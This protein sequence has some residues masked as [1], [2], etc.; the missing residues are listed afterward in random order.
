MRRIWKRLAIAALVLIVS[1]LLFTTTASFQQWLLRR[2]ENYAKQA[3][4]PFTA[5]RL[6]VVWSEL[7]LSLDGLT[8]DQDGQRLRVEH[9]N[10]DLPWRPYRSGDLRIT[11]FEADGVVID[12]RS[13]GSTT[14][15]TA[16]TASQPPH[17]RIDHLAI[18]NAALSFSSPGT[19][20]SAPAVSLEAT[21]GR[22]SILLSSPVSIS[23]DIQFEV[24]RIPFVLLDDSLQFGSMDW[25]IRYADY[26]GAG[27]ADGLVRWAPA[28]ALNA[29]IATEA[30]TIQKWKDI[31]AIAK[32]SYAEGVLDV[33]EFRATQAGGEITGSAK[34]SDVA[35]SS[36]ISWKDLRLDPIG[37]IARTDGT[38]ELGW[39]A[40]DFSDALGEGHA[41]VRSPQYGTADTNIT[42]SNAKATVDARASVMDAAVRAKIT[43][44]LDQ[45]LRGT[46]QVVYRKYGLVELGGTVAGTFQNPTANGQLRVTGA[47]YEEFGPLNASATTTFR[48]NIVTLEEIQAESKRS[49]LSGGTV[50][51]NVTNRRIHGDVPQIQANLNDFAPQV[52]GVVDLTANID[53]SLEQPAASFRG[54]SAGIDVGGTHID[55]VS[56]DGNFANNSLRVNRLEAHQADGTLV[57]SGSLNIAT[58]QVDAELEAS[59]IDIVQVADLSTTVFM[60]AKVH[61]AYR[62]P[63]TDFAGELRDVVYQKQEHGTV[64]LEGTT[65]GKVATVQVSAD[66]YAATATGDITVEEPYPFTM[67]LKA[68]HTPIQYEQY[69]FIAE[70]RIEAAGQ[71]QPLKATHLRFDKFTLAAE[72]VDLSADGLLDTGIRLNVTADLPKLP[73]KDM[74]LGGTAEVMATVRGTINNPSI[75]GAL[76][77]RNATVRT[78]EMTDAATVSADVDFTGAEFSIRDLRASFEEATA[79]VTGRGSWQGTGQF[80]FRVENLKPERFIKDRPIKG[81]ASVEGEVN[82]A[83]PTLD[84]VSGRARVTQLELTVR[85]VAIHQTQPIEAEIDHHVLTVRQLELEGLD[86]HARVTGNANLMDRTLN[87]EAEADTD[88]AVLQPF[89]PNASPGGRLKTHIALNGTPENPNLDGFVNVSGGELTLEQ[90][91]IFLTAVEVAAEL[92][93]DHVQIT[94]ATGLVNGGPFEASGEATISAN[95][96][97]DAR[98][99]LKL[100]HAQMDYPPGLNSEVSAELG[101]NGSMPALTLTGDVNVLNAL[102]EERINLTQEVFSRITSRPVASGITPQSSIGDQI[103]MEVNVQT[104]GPV[105]IKNNL[106]DLEITG[107]FRVRG[108]ASN[109]IILGRAIVQDGGELYFGPSSGSTTNQEAALGQRGDRYTIERGAIDFNNPLR[110]EPTF[111]FEA[112][113]ELKF[114]KDEDYLITLTVTGT[115][116]TLKTELTSSDPTQTKTDIIFMLVTGRSPKDVE[117][118]YVSIA[119]EQ[120][121]NYLSGQLTERVL[122]QAGSVLG[123][124]TVRIDPVTVANQTDVTARLTIGKDI[125]KDFS[126]AYSQ[127][128]NDSNA[129]TWIASYAAF[130]NFVVRGVNDTEQN[131]LQFDLNHEIRI[132]GGPELPKR[133]TLKNEAVL[134]NITFTGTQL[135]MKDLLKQVTKPGKPFNVFRMNGDVR[136]L[137]RYYASN[138]FPLVRIQAQQTPDNGK[139]DVHFKIMDGPRV[140]LEYEGAKVPD[141][142]KAEINQMWTTRPAEGPLLRDTT[143]RLLRHFRSEGY[144]QA[145]VSDKDMSTGP[146]YRHHVFIIDPGKEFGAPTWIFKGVDP[147]AI[148]E[149]AGVVMEHPEAV[150]ERIEASFRPNGYLDAT[151]TIPMLEIEENRAHFV[152]TVNRGNQ[153]I[154]DKVEF[155]GNV[156]LEASRL[157]DAIKRDAIKKEADKTGES[158]VP[159]TSA[160]LETAR[161]RVTSE[162][163]E[164]GF[165]DVQIVPSTTSDPDHSRVGVRF[166]ISEGE[167]QVIKSVEVEGATVTDM[168]YIQRHLQFKTGDPVDYSKFNLTRKKLYDT[169]L[170]RRVDIEAVP[171]GEGYVARVRLNE[172]PP[173]RLRYGFVVTDHL[174][175][176]E[177]DLGVTSDISYNNLFGR[178][179]TTGGRIKVDADERDGRV[180]GSVPEFYGRN[181]TTTVTL[182]RTRELTDPDLISDF[183]GVTAQQQWRFQKYYVLS[184]DYSF[185]KERNYPRD[186]TDSSQGNPRIPIARFNGTVSR[187]TRDDILNAARGTFLSNSFEIAPPGIGSS[188]LFFRNYS[189]YLHFKPVKKSLVWASGFRIGLGAGF[190]GQDLSINDKF[191]AGGGSSV[192]GFKQDQLTPE[193]G[194][195]VL[196]F[197]Q[198]LRFPVLWKFSGV[199]FVDAGLVGE[200]LE[201]VVDLSQL[202]YGT[203]FGLRIHTPFVLLRTDLGW[204]IRPRPGES[205]ARFSFGIGQAF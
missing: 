192:R 182:F 31:R 20:I 35:N 67:E 62:L 105:A 109:P 205:T 157:R 104:A 126:L 43:T 134:R 151:S 125:T 200:K 140:V 198:E 174:Q 86:T 180:F 40:P 103:R 127:I 202:R 123:L 124:N 66:K 4:F 58:E 175:T 128:L 70:G 190:R 117:S 69:D 171:S 153:Y 146:D 15:S 92:R 189:T 41:R 22:G 94:R 54:S 101:L 32:V 181:V 74:E 195:S 113:H 89:V 84:G 38:L 167:R 90:P 65:H 155:D 108:T 191:H 137:R 112:T 185:R 197:N 178:G 183:W 19:T 85:D 116:E 100:E 45:T 87:F 169:R 166:T 37:L 110:T 6:R 150:K 88:L 120:T 164:D 132:G 36:R 149:N 141:N 196:I 7:K 42:I 73:V 47:S 9:L 170:F 121:L 184:Y 133:K 186:A 102:Y 79:T 21:D 48:N 152:V 138:Q 75:E 52:Q 114:G 148:N 111:D 163:W 177:R 93:L 130:K 61:G 161:Q 34:I 8:Y 95:G 26:S 11:N 76:E 51:L 156:A 96:L 145:A 28:V 131:E 173:W 29:N 72:G 158:G 24:P 136:N 78:K 5:A 147:I 3:G 25:Q 97:R 194:N 30:I 16:T 99:Q 176:N 2:A 13:S 142:I 44:G 50:Q 27:S 162:Y 53:G 71:A 168:G 119:G 83:S 143:N 204:N 118:S 201:N 135:S 57:A 115:P 159:F 139:V 106:A 39:K 64:R 12:I 98:F 63:D 33:S 59:N 80:G 172:N 122:S 91:D 193:P 18:R 144:L 154:V 55:N 77:T 160:W 199:T 81:I 14:P 49:H 188:I 1:L 203:G 23:P 82:L 46:Y 129:Q 10:V 68:N 165:N 60:K 56:L 107:S 179:I 187:D 17:I